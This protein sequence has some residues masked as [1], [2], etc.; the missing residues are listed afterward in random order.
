[1]T[2][3]GFV[4]R[5]LAKEGH[6]LQQLLGN[7]GLTRDA[8][9]DPEFQTQIPRL[10][11]FILNAVDQTGEPHLGIRLAKQFEASFIGLPAYAAMN[12]ATFEAALKVLNRFFHLAFPAIEFMFPAHDAKTRP[13][14]FAIQL[15]PKIPLHEISY[16]AS[17]SA[18]VACDGLCKAILRTP[19][20]ALRGELSVSRP[21]GWAD[22]EGQIGFPVVFEAS[23][24][25][26]FF[27]DTL[28]PQPLPGEDPLNHPRLVALCEHVTQRAV[29][30]TT[31]VGKVTS[32]L[33]EG[34]NFALPISAVAE[35]LRYSERGLRRHLERS[36]TTFL[37][38]TNEIREQRARGMLAN[39]G[40]P[41]KTIAHDLG[42]DT[43]SN[44]ARSFKR[45]TGTSPSAFRHAANTEDG[46][47]QN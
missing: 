20:A 10:R 43:P 9:F 32:F 7:T 19:Q 38:L 22:V 41:I 28:L 30:A 21:M 14:E 31:P 33:Q 13:G 34:R 6:D 2:Y 15:Q 46:S 26:L 40:I 12:A 35:A 16:F 3:P 45:W 27:A 24:I 29:A 11:R 42:F 47:G 8:L 18:L 5:V 37:K 17:V 4:F 25:R 36:G 39:T 1:M 44:F 23:A